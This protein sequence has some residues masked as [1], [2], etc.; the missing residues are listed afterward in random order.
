VETLIVILLVALIAAVLLIGLRIAKPQ[1]APAAQ[2]PQVTVTAPPIEIG[3]IIDAVKAG[4][5]KDGIAAAVRVAVE[6]EVRKTAQEALAR[7]NEQAAK[8]ANERLETH[9]AKIDDQTRILLQPFEAQVQA[10][11]AQVAALQETYA[12][13]KG[14]IETL[15][16][17]LGGLQ[18]TTTSLRN[19]LK[20]PTAR[21]S[22]G[23]NQ[24]RNVIKLA[25]MENYCDFTEQFTGT[26]NERNQRPDAVINLPS[27]GHIAVDSKAPLNAYLRMQEATDIAVQE[28]ELKQHARDL[29]AHVKALAD[30][31]YWD[32]FGHN[33]PDFVVMFIPGEGFVADAMK[34]DTGLMDEAMRSRVLIASPVNLLALLLTIA[35]GWQSHRL[36]EQA[37]V[38]AKLGSELYDRVGNVLDE[39]ITMGRAI[40]TTNTAYNKMV[41]SLEGRLLVTLRRF[42]ELGVVQENAPIAEISPVDK[43]PRP[44]T[45]PEAQRLEDGPKEL[46]SP[47]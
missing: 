32:Q 4:V 42:K 34:A 38:V 25:G 41:A 40:G 13:E 5:D 24:L 43:S 47:D 1:Q 19:A 12:N 29:K 17:Q 46:G 20:S 6:A 37:E 30:R 14:T 35:K 39:V 22:W 23:E 28:N 36:N 9:G 44:L 45:S 27:G 2:A 33:T 7:N 31:R 8:Q 15:A 18:E 21:G 10:L 26:E 11:T 16:T 3:P